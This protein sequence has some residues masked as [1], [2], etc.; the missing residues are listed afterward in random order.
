[1]VEIVST[2]SVG[3]LIALITQIMAR[4]E[5]YVKYWPGLLVLKSETGQDVWLGAMTLARIFG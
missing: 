1:M 2:Y 4:T 3:N 5:W